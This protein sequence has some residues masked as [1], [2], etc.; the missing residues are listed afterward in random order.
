V[1]ASPGRAAITVA[2]A[3]QPVAITASTASGTAATGVVPSW[4]AKTCQLS[5]PHAIP[6]G[7]PI[8][9]AIAASVK[10]C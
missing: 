8:T 1:A 6:A 3:S 5:L 10:A 7:T 9:R 2:A 4:C